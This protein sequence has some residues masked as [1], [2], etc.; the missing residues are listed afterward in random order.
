MSNIN[1]IF[2]VITVCWNEVDV[3]RETCESI[4]NQT[5]SSFEWIVIDGGSSDGT[6]KVL[7]EYSEHM[8][9]YVSEKD[10]GIYNGMNK[11]IAQAKGEYVIFMNGGDSFANFSAL[12]DASKVAQKDLLYGDLLFDGN[13]VYDITYPEQLPSSYL[14]WKMLPHQATFIK[15]QLLVDHGVYDE[16]Y[17][18]AGDYEL[19]ARLFE[20]QGASSQHIPSVVARFNG[21]GISNNPAHRQLRKQEN[22]RIRK[23]YFKKYPRS[24]KCLRQ[25]VRELILGR[26]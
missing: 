22:H 8:A 21:E 25:E 26:L 15:R 17:K 14:L 19:F 16:S 10:E 20:L 12:E 9:Y 4:V 6:Q 7:E 3:I 24:L 13:E 5:Y 11:G 18:I 23:M 1:P 2:S